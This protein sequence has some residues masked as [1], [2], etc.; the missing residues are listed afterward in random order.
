MERLDIYKYTFGNDFFYSIYPEM[1]LISGVQQGN[2]VSYNQVEDLS[3]I[4]NLFYSQAISYTQLKRYLDRWYSNNSENETLINKNLHVL[5]KHVTI[6]RSQV[7]EMYGSAAYNII[8][9]YH[10]KSV[11]CRRKLYDYAV[12]LVRKELKIPNQLQVLGVIL[13]NDFETKYVRYGIEGLNYGDPA[14]GIMDYIEG[15]NDFQGTGLVDS[16]FTP[17]TTTL[18]DLVEKLKQLLVYGNI[19]AI[20]T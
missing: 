15:T 11:K 3:K 12:T 19:N 1:G 6:P 2:L 20:L 17:N 16:G 10:E 4:E 14:V 13:N 18:Q 8:D 7:F 5:A 9:E